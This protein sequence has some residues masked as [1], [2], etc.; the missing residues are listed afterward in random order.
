VSGAANV[1]VI[2]TLLD[3]DTPESSVTV[4]RKVSGRVPNT[5][6]AINVGFTVVGLLS[7]TCVPESCTHAYAAMVPSGS[8][9][10]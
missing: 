9:E 4:K 5:D 6:G 7:V 8:T 10:L 1:F 3:A 2:V